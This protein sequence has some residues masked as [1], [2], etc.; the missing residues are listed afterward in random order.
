MNTSTGSGSQLSLLP[1]GELSNPVGYAAP[2][3]IQTRHGQAT[4][5]ISAALASQVLRDPLLM[6]RL[7]DRVYELLLND[8]RYQRERSGNF[9]GYHD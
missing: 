7:S 2:A 4:G 5:G 1:I 6:R 3:S 9:G 8:L